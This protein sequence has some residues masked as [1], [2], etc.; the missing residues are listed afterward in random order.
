MDVGLKYETA[1]ETRRPC[2]ARPGKVTDLPYGGGCAALVEPPDAAPAAAAPDAGEV[3]WFGRLRRRL[4][5]DPDVVEV[6]VEG[7]SE[8]EDEVENLW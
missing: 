4:A 2:R 7:F 5:G 8:S 3:G 6:S 1:F